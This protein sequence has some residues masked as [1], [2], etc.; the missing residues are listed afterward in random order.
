VFSPREGTPAAK[1]ED[2]LS[3]E[4]KKKRLYRLN[5]LVNDGYQNGTNRFEG[6]IVKV[7]VDGVSKNN[8][9]V[10]AGYTENNKLVNF[11]GDKK[12]IG[13]IV[14]VKVIEAKTWHMLGEK[15]E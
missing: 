3:I 8:D 12:L 4:D 2:T 1:F 7:L 10:L 15:I 11:I 13:E 9:Q 5:K 14:Q 6:K